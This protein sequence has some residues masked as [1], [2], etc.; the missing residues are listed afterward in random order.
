M[1]IWD[2]WEHALVSPHN[3]HLSNTYPTIGISKRCHFLSTSLNYR[4]ALYRIDS[5][6]RV[7]QSSDG[8]RSTIKMAERLQK[9]SKIL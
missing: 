1:A 8:R 5:C 3:H 9:F 2:G 4:L 6:K 7:F